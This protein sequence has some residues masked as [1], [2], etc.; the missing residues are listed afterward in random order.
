[1]NNA[2]RY[3]LTT[4]VAAC[5]TLLAT[6]ITPQ[7]A[8]DAFAAD[9]MLR[10]AAMTI[11]VRDI[12]GDSLVAAYRPLTATVTASTMKTIT[13]VAALELLGGDFTFKTPV[14]LQGRR[15]KKKFKGDIV[16]G[17]SYDPTISTR[18]IDS[19]PDLVREIV[20]ALQQAGIEKIE[21]NIRFADEPVFPAYS[22]EWNVED[23]GWGYG[24]GVHNFNYNDNI[25][26]LA[27]DVDSVTGAHS[28]PIIT[29]STPG[30]NIAFHT[31]VGATDEIETTA[32]YTQPTVVLMGQMPRG[33]N[34]F[35]IA[36]PAPRATMTD[37]LV[38]AL[39]QAG[40]K[41]KQRSKP[42]ND[43]RLNERYTLLTHVS[44]PLT[45]IVR[46]L[47]DR[48]DNMYTQALF[49]VLPIYSSAG[50]MPVACVRR[51]MDRLGVDHSGLFMRD[52]SGLARRGRASGQF[53][54][55]VLAA[56]ADRRYA[57]YRLVDL[58]P[59]AGKR[60][61]NQL[62]TT[63]LASD[64][65]LKSGS[66]GDVQC[67]VGYYPAD[68]PRYAFSLLVNNYN[69]SRTALRNR[70]DTLLINLFGEK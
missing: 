17:C 11:A 49:T 43:S 14:T 21:G 24:T 8:V 69:C 26:R 36:N 68:A 52:G 39:K 58:M 61:G 57:G 5:T 6:A 70:M 18:Y 23:L 38:R 29:P 53:M 30:L 34:E 2:M 40:I 48:S 50:S 63:P 16:I 65:H 7:Q 31:T 28:T 4:L 35:N 60:V 41:F 47:L 46:S 15:D 9:S 25:V 66:M 20:N 62:P 67:F 27:Y 1:M 3:L 12:Q 51:V 55:D 54:V 64:I 42:W 56:V 44:P 59:Q 13:S 32:E 45:T 37:S 22:I 33:H 19:T 10:H